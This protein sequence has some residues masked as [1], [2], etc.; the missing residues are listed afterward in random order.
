MQVHVLKIK[1]NFNDK[2]DALYPV[3]LKNETDT[4]LVDCCYQGF[5]P[6]IEKAMELYQISLEQLTGVIITH[7]DID[8]MGGL[9]ELKERLPG[10]KVYASAIDKPYIEGKAK[11]LRLQQAEDLFDAIPEEQKPGALYFQELLRSMK[12]VPVDEAFSDRTEPSF[13]KGAIIIETPGHMPGHI[14][15]YLKDSKT[16]IAADAFIIEEDRFQIANPQYTLNMAQAITSIEKLSALDIQKV[17]CYH[18]GT[19]EQNVSEKLKNLLEKYR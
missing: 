15:I 9:F 7:H 12:H 5:L 6:L 11:S 16:L 8:H 17:I 2:E 1:F 19:T 4:I 18:G 3:I 13:L 10:L 14:S